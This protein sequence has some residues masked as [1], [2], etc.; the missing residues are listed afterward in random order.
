MRPIPRVLAICQDGPLDGLRFSVA[1]PSVDA[2]PQPLTVEGVTYEPD[3][4]LVLAVEQAASI[5]AQRVGEAPHP[6]FEGFDLHD[7]QGDPS[8]VS[9]HDFVSVWIYR[10]S[11]V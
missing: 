11:S 8:V 2:E 3:C 4:E 9:G 5:A 10:E 7:D 1:L 6:V